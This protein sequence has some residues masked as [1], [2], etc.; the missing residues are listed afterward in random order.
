MYKNIFILVLEILFI[1]YYF[2][3][4]AIDG[5]ILHLQRP[6]TS[7]RSGHHGEGARPAQIHDLVPEEEPQI[8]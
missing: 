6:H 4:S 1:I 5:G 3:I 7:G 8:V 2:I